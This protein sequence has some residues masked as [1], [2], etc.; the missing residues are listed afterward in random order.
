MARQH[1]EGR[2]MGAAAPLF[3]DD[4]L[5]APVRIGAAHA[6]DRRGGEGRRLAERGPE[7]HAERVSLQASSR[8]ADA[9]ARP[10]P[11]VVDVVGERDGERRVADAELPAQA[12]ERRV[13]R[14]EP[15]RFRAEAAV[16]VTR[17]V[18][19]LHTRKMEEAGGEVVAGQFPALDLLPRLR[20]IGDVVAEAELGRADRV[21]NPARTALDLL[22][23]H[24]TT[25]RA[26]RAR[27][28]NAGFGSST[29]K[30]AS[31]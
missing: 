11:G 22:G 7:A 5:E 1:E 17:A 24:L 13:E 23:D 2:A 16:L 18:P 29:A 30:T 26:T 20:V 6:V 27:W 21:E 28:T 15:R 8:G 10:P 12:L 19:L 3:G 25:L 9:D 4:L 14:V 31:T